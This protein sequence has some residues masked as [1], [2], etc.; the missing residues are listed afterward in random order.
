MLGTLKSGESIKDRYNSHLHEDVEL[1]LSEAFLKID[2]NDREFIVE[3]IEMGRIIG[4]TTCV[5]TKSKDQ[6]F[7]AQRPNRNG[8]TRFV[9]NRKSELCSTVVVIL[10][11]IDDED[12]DYVL[13]TSFIGAIAEVEPWDSRATQKSFNFWAERAL[14]MDNSNEIIPGTETT[15]CPW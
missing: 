2:S 6:I 10:K 12:Y 8:L 4:S 11:K 3:E 7:Y 9:K 13:I 5:K 15:I 1:I 14:V